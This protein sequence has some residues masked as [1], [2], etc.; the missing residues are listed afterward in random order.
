MP[1]RPTRSKTPLSALPLVGPGFRGLNT[2]LS[3]T[4]GLVDSLW[5][6][7]LREAVYDDKGRVGLRKGWTKTNASGV[8]DATSNT[9]LE[10]HEFTR[11][12]GTTSLVKQ[13]A[14]KLWASTDDGV[15]WSD[16]TGS[17]T[18]GSKRWKFVNFNDSVIGVAPG[19]FPIKYIGSGN[20]ATLVAGSGILPV[21]NGVIL[22]AYGRL[23]IV[24][25]ATGAIVYTALLDETL[26]AAADGGG[27]LDTS[28]VW[29]QGTDVIT[30]M[31][32]FGA[33]IAVFGKRHVLLYTDG[34]GSALGI[35]PDD[36][37]VADT[38][39]GT[40]CIARDAVVAIG[41]GDLWFLSQQGVQSLS[42]VVSD[43]NN[44]LGSVS[45][46]VD[47]LIAELIEAEPDPSYT[48]KGVYSPENQFVLF[49]F[50]ASTRIVMFDTRVA[51][52][53]GSFRAAEWRSQAHTCMC[54]R[55]NRTL[56]FG[57][58]SGFTAYYNGYRDDTT[59][60]SPTVYKLIYGGPWTDFG[61]EAH[62][63]VKIL[64]QASAIILGRE[65]LT[66]TARWAFDFRALEYSEAVTNDY[67][68]SGGEFALG[69]FGESEW[70]TGVRL[71]RQYFAGA[72]EGQFVKFWL[73]I[74]S[75]D[76]AD[77]VSLQELTMYAKIGRML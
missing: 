24:E 23:W 29:T 51:L 33:A 69:E 53:D 16:I 61:P 32:A 43:K 34:A 76:V 42:R 40:G 47:S 21:S 4:V 35:S 64:K 71:R 77:R 46:N 5:A 45:R 9:V 60:V 70:G 14:S 49:L 56:L 65:T 2:E 59:A 15:N 58:P 55:Q 74:E 20:F 31:V 72:G 27:A 12:D 25:D 17:V 18:V 6:L 39:E 41:E 26:F 11:N 13:T 57:R 63:R 28:N 37:Y 73:E 68:S 22:S 67:V 44:P 38:I 52:E 1:A 75:T 10:E 62:S 36:I 54:Q 7:D 3:D 50:P 66:I 30:A 8:V 19:E 48:V